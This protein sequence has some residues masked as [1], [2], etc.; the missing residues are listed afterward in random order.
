MTKY[1]CILVQKKEELEATVNA[2]LKSYFDWMFC[3]RLTI[4]VE[5]IVYMVLNQTG[6]SPVRPKTKLNNRK[7]TKV[8]QY[9][10]LG[11][12]ITES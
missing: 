9:K 10:Y 7:L 5:K 3:T 4:Y 6:K 1:H 11:L 8:Q 2:D 12:I